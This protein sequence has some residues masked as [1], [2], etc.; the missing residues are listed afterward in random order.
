MSD[1]EAIVNETLNNLI[2]QH[3]LVPTIQR[4]DVYEFYHESDLT[5]NV[6]NHYSS[7]VFS[8][9]WRFTDAS[10]SLAKHLYSASTHPNIG[11]G[12]FLTILFDDI[13]TSSGVEQGIGFYRIE[14]KSD[15]LDVEDKGGV[16]QVVDRSGISLDRIQKGAIVLSGGRRVYAIDSLSAKTKYW[17][18]SFLKV[19]S[20]A[21]SRACAKAAGD[22]IKRI[23]EEAE[24]PVDAIS[25]GKKLLNTLSES[26]SSSIEQIKIIAAEYVGYENVGTILENVK[27]NIG[28]DIPDGSGI[29]SFAFYPGES[30]A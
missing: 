5:L 16:I 4:G 24:R 21:S 25:F 19:T 6:V 3:Y 14:G 17:L 23:A 13:R 20:S 8:D 18:D 12:E 1:S 29:P 2:L 28:C 26:D 7:I 15:Y 10:I 27:Q 30:M 11:G 9:N 22:F